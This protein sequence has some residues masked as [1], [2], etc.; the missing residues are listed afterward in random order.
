MRISDWSSDVCSSDL[1]G[2]AERDLKGERRDLQGQRMPGQ[3]FF[4]DPSHQKGGAGKQARLGQDDEADR[5]ADPHDFPETRP[6]GTPPIAEDMIAPQPPVGLE[7]RKS[8]RL[9]S[10][11]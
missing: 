5:Q 10:S 3:L 11:P 4:A 6:F 1:L 2:D 7:D 9:N 8:T